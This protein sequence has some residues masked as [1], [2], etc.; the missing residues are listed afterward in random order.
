MQIRQKYAAERGAIRQL[1]TLYLILVGHKMFF[2]IFRAEQKPHCHDC[3]CRRAC[4]DCDHFVSSHVPF[5]NWLSADF[6]C[7]PHHC[8][9]Y[10][11][12]TRIIS[13]LLSYGKPVFSSRQAN[14]LLFFRP[15][16][17]ILLTTLKWHSPIVSHFSKGNEPVTDI[18][19]IT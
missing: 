19:L 18:F 16:D 10:A 9:P 17:N 14:P 15:H 8:H 1:R 7:C 3:Q 11:L 5:S 12:Q 6:C 13:I 2:F 4:C